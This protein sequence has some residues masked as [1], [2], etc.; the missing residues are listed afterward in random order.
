MPSVQEI[1]NEIERLK[2]ET[3]TTILVHAYQGQDIFEI[4]D[5]VGDSYGLAIKAQDDPSKN[6]LMCGV[7]FMAETAKILCPNKRVFLPNPTAGCPMAEQLTKKE[8]QALK[9]QF[10]DHSVVAY[11]NTTAELKTLADVCVTSSCA[12]EVCRNLENDK[13]LFI[14]DPNLGS[15]VAEKLPEK[16]FRFIQG[17][18]PHHYSMTKEDVKKAKTL[19]PDA[20]LLVHPECP[21]D[22]VEEAD[23]VG[24]TTGI[25]NFAKNSD[26]KEF[27]I[28]TEVSIVE[29]LQFDCPDKKFYALSNDLLCSDMKA[30]TLMDVY[31]T[32]KG[33]AGEEIIL[34]DQTIE[35]ARH[36]LDEMIRLG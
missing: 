11:V 20:L 35:K 4:A 33:I 22:V 13:I 26:H 17:G 2:K 24:A 30:T 3:D 16:Q 23:Y 7:R 28:G 31:N 21:K 29:H 14:P 34:D 18:C 12:V 36:S 6:I 32:L 8:L 10:P 1:K 27:V 25:M 9:E 5:Y 19:H 15:Y